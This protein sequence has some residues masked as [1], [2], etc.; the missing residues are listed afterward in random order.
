MA[1]AVTGPRRRTAWRMRQA[2]KLFA[3][4]ELMHLVMDEEVKS[5]AGE[6]HPAAC[7]IA[8]PRNAF[9]A[10]ITSKLI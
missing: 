6:R 5:L 1:L 8:L 10:T 2:P 4:L 3:G 9:M 7:S